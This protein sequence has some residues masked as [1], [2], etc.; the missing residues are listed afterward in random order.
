MDDES[1]H[2][3]RP[4][5]ARSFGSTSGWPSDAD[6]PAPLRGLTPADIRIVSL[7]HT[8]SPTRMGSLLICESSKVKDFLA[9]ALQTMQQLAVKRI[10]KAWI[11]GI[12]PRKQAVFPYNKKNKAKKWKEEGIFV[13]ANKP[14]WWPDE[15]LCVFVEPDHI[16]REGK[17]ECPNLSQQY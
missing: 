11:K 1:Y 13:P 6:S 4:A 10:A 12:C 16:K 14:G 17:L 7:S 8:A 5:S 2:S 3:S 15:K 9:R